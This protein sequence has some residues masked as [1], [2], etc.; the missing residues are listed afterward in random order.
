MTSP[1]SKS[2]SL[3][4]DLE[5]PNVDAAVADAMPALRGGIE[6][7]AFGNRKH[8]IHVWYHQQDADWRFIEKLFRH[9]IRYLIAR[10][11]HDV[12]SGLHH[13]K[14]LVANA[15]LLYEQERL[16]GGIMDRREPE[17]PAGIAADAEQS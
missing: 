17:P 12:D 15:I 13:L 3:P 8:G 10:T 14:H 1:S 7:M 9:L 6:A 11:A 2:E 4:F 16:H 5:D